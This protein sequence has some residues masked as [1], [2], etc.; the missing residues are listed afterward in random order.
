MSGSNPGPGPG[1]PSTGFNMTQS[2]EPAKNCDILGATSRVSPVLGPDLPGFLK[3][4]CGW[5][6]EACYLPSAGLDLD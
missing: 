1:Q 4:S 6:E 3:Y 2:P 5:E